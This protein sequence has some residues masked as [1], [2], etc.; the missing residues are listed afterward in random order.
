M[1][2]QGRRLFRS[3]LME[4]EDLVKALLQLQNWHQTLR[5]EKACL[6]IIPAE[7]LWI[8]T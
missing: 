5:W 4:A 6:Y 2:L 3:V 7:V 1:I 8:Q